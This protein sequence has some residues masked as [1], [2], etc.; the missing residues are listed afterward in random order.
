MKDYSQS[1]SL[2]HLKRMNGQ[3]ILAKTGDSAPSVPT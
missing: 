1:K 3:V 2:I